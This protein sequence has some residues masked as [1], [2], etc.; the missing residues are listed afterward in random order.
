MKNIFKRA[1]AWMSRG[2][3]FMSEDEMF[4]DL[5]KELPPST[6]LHLADMKE[7][8]LI[9]T[10]HTLGGTIRNHYRLWSS[11]NPHTNATNP[12]SEGGIITDPLFPDAVSQR[13]IERIWAAMQ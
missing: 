8:D 13:L 2:P 10:H 4:Q 5:M 3:E 7:S 1:Y 11:D 12:L 9:L 6:L